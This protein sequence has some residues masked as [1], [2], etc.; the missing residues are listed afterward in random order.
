MIELDRQNGQG[1]GEYILRVLC[2]TDLCYR[3]VFIQLAC[4]SIDARRVIKQKER[5]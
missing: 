5:G 2:R 1:G 4:Q 3:N